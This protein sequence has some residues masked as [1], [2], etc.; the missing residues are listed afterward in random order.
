MQQSKYCLFIFLLVHLF[1]VA[2]DGEFSLVKK[3]VWNA[4]FVCPENTA[5]EVRAAVE[6]FNSIAEK[7]IGKPADISPAE[8]KGKGKILLKIE[9]RTLLDDD[10]FSIGFPDTG[11]MLITATERSLYWAFNH[12]LENFFGARF[13]FPYNQRDLY[14]GNDLNYYPRKTDISIPAKKIVER[15]V[16]NIA[17]MTASGIRGWDKRWN[18]KESL[19]GI[20]FMMIDVFPVYKYAADGSWPSEIMPVINGKKFF[21]PKAKAPL[22]ENKWLARRGYNA[23]WQ[24]CWSNP[25]TVEIAVANILEILAREPDKKHINLDVNDMGGYCECAECR[26]QVG[27]KLNRLNFSD[28]SGLYWKWVDAIAGKV[29]EKYPDVI[30]HA[31][32]YCEVTNPPDFVLHK[33]ILPRLCFELVSLSDPEAGPERR[34]LLEEWALKA[35]RLDFYD[36]VYSF[37]FYLLPRV[38]YTKHSGY[39]KELIR[40][41]KLHAYYAASFGT[42]PDSGPNLYLIHKILW[43]DH[44]DVEKTVNDWCVSAVGPKA[45]PYLRQ[46]YAF[47]EKYWDSAELK[48]TQWYL[49]V[50]NVYMNLGEKGTYTFALKKGDMSA[51]RKLLETVAALADT[52]KSK[53][54]A[55]EILKFFEFSEDASKALFSELIQPDGT[56]ASKEDALALLCSIPAALEAAKRMKTHPY[57]K[58]FTSLNQLEGW[59]LGN[60]GAVLPYLVDDGVKNELEKQIGDQNIPIL[61]RS[62]FRVWLGNKPVNRIENGS[63]EEKSP[64]PKILFSGAPVE[65]TSVKASDGTNSLRLYNSGFRWIIPAKPEKTYLVMFDTYLP[66]PSVEGRLRYRLSNALDNVFANHVNYRNIVLSSGKWETYCGVCK[67]FRPNKWAKYPDQLFLDIYFQKFDKGENVYLDNVRIYCLDELK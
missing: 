31:I 3:G 57:A 27:N 28:Y 63:F 15:P 9:K 42:F 56:L 38:Y 60:I 23:F 65:T 61:Y 24:P 46:Y 50:R 64:Y 17:R 14:G 49:S 10:G 25:R 20:H 45:A 11:T 1:A 66:K 41:Y 19:P 8:I 67:T 54:R 52:P 13:I 39:L 36:Y 53:K 48:K 7:C 21:P 44:T 51:Q 6:Y 43:N 37:E 5:A 58:Y 55:G 26:K 22:P 30:F 32:A 35:A 47:W 2:D 12:L 29:T 33:N 16:V 18:A 59:Q 34:K 62:V 40:K 4:S